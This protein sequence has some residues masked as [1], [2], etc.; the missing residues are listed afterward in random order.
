M[1][2]AASILAF[3]SGTP[4]L[5]YVIWA[6]ILINAIFSFIQE[7]RADKALQALS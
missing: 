6:I 2:W 3:I 4:L 1:L 5:S 7:N